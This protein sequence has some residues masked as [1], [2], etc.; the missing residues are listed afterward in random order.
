[1]GTTEQEGTTEPQPATSEAFTLEVQEPNP[2]EG[3][4]QPPPTPLTDAELIECLE[5]LGESLGDLKEHLA[6]ADKE[7]KKSLAKWE[8]ECRGRFDLERGEWERRLKK[9]YDEHEALSQKVR[10]WLNTAGTEITAAKSRQEATKDKVN[11]LLVINKAYG[12]RLDVLERKM[13]VLSKPKLN[14]DRRDDRPQ[15]RPANGDRRRA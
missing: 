8:G 14:G 1:M 13:E 9:L 7:L 15:G 5:S 6:T 2:P 12:E 3:V 10:G 11:A 4:T